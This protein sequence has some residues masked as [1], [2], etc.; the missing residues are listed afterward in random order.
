[1]FLPRFS[2]LILGCLL[3]VVAGCGGSRQGPTDPPA[4]PVG[5]LAT[6]AAGSGEISADQIARMQQEVAAALAHLGQLFPSPPSH[7]FSVFVHGDR[8]GL[9]A[10][11]Q[12][13]LLPESPAFALLGRH[14]IH[15]VWGELIRTATSLRGAVV[16]E[17]VHELL[18]QH[19]APHGRLLPRWFHEG[20]AQCLAGDTYLGAREEDL[21]WRVGTRRLQPFSSLRDGFPR[22]E[23]G[24]RMAYAQS[25]SYVSWLLAEYGLSNL[26]T[27]AKAT[28]DLTSFERALVGRTGRNTLQL[29]EAWHDHLLHGSGASWRALFEQCFSFLLIGALPV[30]ALAMIRRFRAEE[31]A[32]ARLADI[33]RRAAAAAAQARAAAERDALATQQPPHTAV[34]GARAPDDPEDELTSRP[35]A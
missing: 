21:V 7:R 23:E 19:S 4:L 2:S 26:L 5:Q 6:V 30:L 33:E 22:D 27:V 32:A 15:I 3:A 11:L 13:H 16:H 17:L 12:P 1:M 24:L 9:P 31:R 18:D 14:Q 28:D 8:A 25:Y 10:A 35:E 29:E 34:D 20:L